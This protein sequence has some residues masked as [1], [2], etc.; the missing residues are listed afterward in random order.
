[1]T[2][3]YSATVDPSKSTLFTPGSLLLLATHTVRVGG[4]ESRYCHGKEATQEC[5][6]TTIIHVV[7][8][9]SKM[10]NNNNNNDN[11]PTGNNHEHNTSKIT[12]ILISEPMYLPFCCL[13]NTWLWDCDW[14]SRVFYFC[15]FEGGVRICEEWTNSVVAEVRVQWNMNIKEWQERI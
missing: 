12:M 4:S 9:S 13:L 6:L 7:V 2:A 3:H 14:S 5:A 11:V 1:M 8:T 15:R 10:K